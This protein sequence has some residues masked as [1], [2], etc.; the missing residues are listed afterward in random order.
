MPSIAAAARAARNPGLRPLSSSAV[1]AE[2]FPYIDGLRALAV[3][4]VFLYHLNAAWMPGGFVGVDVFFV[5]SGFVVSAASVSF[6]GHGFWRFLSYFY[7]RRI[8]RIFP[9]LIVCLVLTAFTSVLFIPSSWLSLVNQQTGLYAFF[10]LSNF[11]LAQSGRDYFAP[12]TEYNPF[13]HTWSLAVEEQF[14][15]IFPPLFILW[16]G[17]RKRRWWSVGLLA[18]GSVFSMA[19]SA[20]QSQAHPTEAYF[21]S[22]GRFWELASGV[23]LYQFVSLRP[24]AQRGRLATWGRG[25]FGLLSL[26]ALLAAFVVSTPERFP[27]PGALLAVL[28]T[29]G[30]ILTL[31]HHAELRRLHSLLG[32]RPLVRI[33]RISY[34]LYLWH[35]PVFVLFRWTCG[36]DTL[37]LRGLAAVLAFSLAA[38][39]YRFVENPPRHSRLIRRMPQTAVIAAGLLIAYGSWWSVSR[40]DD[41]RPRL[42]LSTVSRHSEIWYPDGA[43]TVPGYPGCTAEPEPHDVGGGLLMTY[44]PRGC[45]E[46][47][48]LNPAS[49]FV[50]G[51]SHAMAY[52]GLFRQ[53]AIRNATRI[54]AYT[55]GGCPFISLFPAGD[56]DNPACRQYAEA[57][58]RDMRQRIKPGD[59]LFLASLRLPR[60]SSQWVYYGDAAARAQMFGADADA[61]RLRSVA[62]AIG[63]LDDFARHGVRIVFEGPLPVFR[64][65]PFRCADWFN[66]TNPICRPG[67]EMPRALLD[68]YRQPV[69][70]SFADIARQ[71][72]DMGVWDPFAVLCPGSEC[73]AWLGD[74]PLFI[75]GDHLSGF[76]NMQLLPAFTAYMDD[77]LGRYPSRLEDGFVLGKDGIPDFLA[78][79][80]GLSPAESW[81]RWSDAGLARRVRLEF[82]APLP[83]SFVLEISAAAFGPNIGVPVKVI[84]GGEEKEVTF[85]AQQTVA[86]VRLDNG[87][88]SRTIELV[89]PKPTSPSSLGLG[90][91]RRRLGIGIATIKVHATAD[92]RLAKAPDK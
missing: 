55:N 18:G 3:L 68:E 19:F 11:I 59:V 47:Q 76:G 34:S 63:V 4:S 79:V 39:S 72:P 87:S 48:T 80:E 53:Y 69:L 41:H 26:L 54:N 21:L 92:D 74:S 31:H 51:D 42:S 12:L 66:R 85:T 50:I 29:L 2:Y 46:P 35:W 78:Q 10:G 9:A 82:V 90:A 89:P 25:L 24:P 62:Y 22:P 15:L 44:S 16:L 88:G 86:S 8:R 43:T 57:A 73:N 49:I 77:R 17:D 14:Y 84:V 91:D 56:L 27:M 45:L 40:I 81:G 71:L 23:L 13:T 58:L 28:G 36:L 61:G 67:F 1:R 64:A 32:S 37:F 7:A 20:W 6:S 30:V 65:P 5:I 33:G 38:A 75:D 83:R 52:A 70:R 60:F